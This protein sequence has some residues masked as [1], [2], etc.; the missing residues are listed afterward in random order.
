[1]TRTFFALII[2]IALFVPAVR[3]Q[4]ASFQPRPSATA[5][6]IVQLVNERRAAAK[7]KPLTV[8]SVLMTEAQRFS[9]VQA[10]MGKISHRGTDGTNAGQRL[11]KAGYRWAYYGENL[12]AGQE[13]AEEVVAA[14]MASPTHRA[15]V[16]TP[17]A[18]EIGI[19]HT[20]SANDQAGYYDY[21][22]MEIGRAR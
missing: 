13:T 5:E 22:A 1:M 12:A 14:W 20:F 15:N 11:S 2:F 19:G 18:R 17:K 16:L 9:G 4:A 7:L 3:T 8:N 21:Y 6:R 10:E